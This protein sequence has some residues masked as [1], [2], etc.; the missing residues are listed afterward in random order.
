MDAEQGGVKDAGRQ[1]FDD[2]QE[3]RIAALIA[4]GQEPTRD[5]VDYLLS[6]LAIQR[7]A[8]QGQDVALRRYQDAARVADHEQAATL[9]RALAE[10]REALRG[11]QST[12]PDSFATARLWGRL[13]E[14][15][16]SL[17]TEATG[18]DPAD[19]AEIDALVNLC[20]EL[21]MVIESENIRD[22][23]RK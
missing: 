12:R 21:L 23:R 20:A 22:A 13:G 17:A 14:L 1:F 16:H 7:A 19:W 11:K 2:P 6:M 4:E 9:A 18:D 10:L 3:Q 5:M 15:R 8:L